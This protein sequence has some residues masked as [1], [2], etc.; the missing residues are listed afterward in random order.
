MAD[1]MYHAMYLDER[2]ALSPSDLNDAF[3][4]EDG[5]TKLLQNHLKKKYERRCNVNGYIRAGSVE[6]LQRSMGL[7]ENGRFNGNFVYDCKFKSQVLYPTAGT[8][9][10]AT[11]LK[12]NKMGVYAIFEDADVRDEVMIRILLPRD[13]HLGNEEFDKI[14]EGDKLVVSLERSKF[15]TNDLFI[16]SVGRLV[17][18]VS[19]EDAS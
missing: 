15:Q 6:V 5:I 10:Q 16:V 18:R 13:I 7:A 3:T 1:S 8:H 17:R 12:V 11:V 19:A 4:I 14:E 9:I 2:V